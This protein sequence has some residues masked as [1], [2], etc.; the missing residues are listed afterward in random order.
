[1]NKNSAP[2]SN[3]VIA[4][5]KRPDG[6][7][8]KEIRIRDGFRSEE[9]GDVRVYKSL[10]VL[11]SGRADQRMKRDR[12]GLGKEQERRKNAGIPGAPPP[13]DSI[14]TK[15]KMPPTKSARRRRNR[16]GKKQT[17]SNQDAEEEDKQG[18]D[19]NAALELTAE[20]DTTSIEVSSLL[21]SSLFQ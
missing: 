6:T 7:V 18:D 5:S 10:G 21:L 1:M 9:L 19:S 2:Q 4:A 16:H 20:A 17:E 8:R 11:V 14:E 3:R 15:D 13:S 12:P